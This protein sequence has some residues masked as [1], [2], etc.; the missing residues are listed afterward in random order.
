MTIKEAY[1]RKVLLQ[2]L[3]DKGLVH[4]EEALT[5]LLEITFQWL[6]ES[7]AKSK[8]PYDD[9]GL[10]ILPPLKSFALGKIDEVDNLDN[11]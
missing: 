5:D 10:V 9:M 6:Q 1:D 4:A 8:T 3:E 7:A 2:R 11:A